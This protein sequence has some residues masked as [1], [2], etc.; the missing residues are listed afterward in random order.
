MSNTLKILVLSFACIIYILPMYANNSQDVVAR[1]DME[2]IVWDNTLTL[3]ALNGKSNPGV[4]GAFSGFAGD[5]LVV[6]GGANFPDATPWEG[7]HKTWWNTLY[8][9]D[10]ST[11]N[12]SWN[13]VENSLPKALA[14]GASIQLPSG[15]LCI[16]GCD[17]VRCY[18]EVFQL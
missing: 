13:I 4:A 18:G 17:S 1:S 7:G 5:M 8:Y 11:S 6:A 9:I 16:G 15:V 10:I 12:S 3:P 14:Y 2:K